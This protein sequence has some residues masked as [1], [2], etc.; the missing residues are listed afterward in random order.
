M[1]VLKQIHDAPLHMGNV[2][3]E[4]ALEKEDISSDGPPSLMNPLE[5][6]HCSCLPDVLT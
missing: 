3:R 6:G 4:V 5:D 2:F 1:S